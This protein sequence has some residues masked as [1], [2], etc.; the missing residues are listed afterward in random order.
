MGNTA[1]SRPKHKVGDIIEQWT[2]HIRRDG[3]PSRHEI[4]FYLVINITESR[5]RHR[6]RFLFYELKSLTKGWIGAINTKIIDGTYQYR[7]D[8]CV[9]GFRKV[10]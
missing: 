3:L 2:H 10:G 9:S 5:V 8:H 6:R 7:I 4:E 1:R